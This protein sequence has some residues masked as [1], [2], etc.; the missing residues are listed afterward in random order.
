MLYY[1][2]LNL[3]FIVIN[4]EISNNE[5]RWEVFMFIVKELGVKA[6]KH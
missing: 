2:H 3:F 6:G 1:T 5:S 4:F